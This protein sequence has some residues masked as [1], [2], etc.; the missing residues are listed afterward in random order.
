MDILQQKLSQE[1]ELCRDHTHHIKDEV[2]L[3]YY[4]DI[5]RF[6]KDRDLFFDADIEKIERFYELEYPFKGHKVF[7]EKM[8]MSLVNNIPE[9]IVSLIKKKMSS[10][11]T[12]PK[13]QVVERYEPVMLSLS[14]MKESSQIIYHSW[15]LFL[16]ITKQKGKSD[17]AKLEQLVKLLELFQYKEPVYDILGLFQNLYNSIIILANCKEYKALAHFKL[18]IHA[19]PLKRETLYSLA[20]REL[21]PLWILNTLSLGDGVENLPRIILSN[22]N[23][24]GYPQLNAPSQYFIKEPGASYSLPNSPH[25]LAV[26]DEELDA[27]ESSLAK[28]LSKLKTPFITRSKTLLRTLVRLQPVIDSKIKILITGDTGTGKDVLANAIHELSQRKGQFKAIN[29]AGISASLFE[30]EI[31]GHE[32]GAFT[33]AKEMKKGAFELADGGTLFLDEIGDLPLEQQAKLL[34]AIESNTF[35]RV[36][37][38]QEIEV[39]VRVISATHINLQKRIEEK[40][41]R[42]DLYSRIN[43]FD[44]EL[45]SLDERAGDVPLLSEI[46]FKKHAK[47]ENVKPPKGMSADTF[48]PLSEKSWPRNVRQ[49]DNHIHR[50][51]AIF[52]QSNQ[53]L[54]DLKLLVNDED[55]DIA[56]ETDLVFTG[57]TDQ[58]CFDAYIQTGCSI[59]KTWKKLGSSKDTMTKIIYGIIVRLLTH[60]GD[61]NASVSFLVDNSMLHKEDTQAF[62]VA[63]KSVLETLKTKISES[64]SLERQLYADDEQ[65]IKEFLNKV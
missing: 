37:G 28:K 51:V 2:I 38:Q 56:I 60:T 13:Y 62:E 46:L 25:D 53:S 26:E 39:D 15:V 12:L 65:R 17:K 24:Y 35:S 61:V 31:F 27:R 40:Q 6:E 52:K 18:I 45:I 4:D 63:F 32:K 58:Q 9:F 23:Q 34:R 41:F 21:T 43:G 22:L 59:N 19:D 57:P 14:N 16:E 30:S 48:L 29:C 11:I 1:F 20:G 3:N 42:E 5:D 55:I 33:D 36:G 64:K 49:L 10:I 8:F 47:L 54:N 7:D 44:V 50:I